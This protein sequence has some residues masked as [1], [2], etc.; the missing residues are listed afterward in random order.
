[1][2]VLFFKSASVFESIIQPVCS[3]YALAIVAA[4]NVIAL[5]PQSV[6][7]SYRIC[8]HAVFRFLSGLFRALFLKHN[9]AAYRYTEILRGEVV[10]RTTVVFIKR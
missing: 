7:E 2:R 9:T 8:V 3:T 1:M 4:L 5:G 6:F 10:G